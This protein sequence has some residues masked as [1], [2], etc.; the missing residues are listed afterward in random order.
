MSKSEQIKCPK[1]NKYVW[2]NYQDSNGNIIKSV[3]EFERFGIFILDVLGLLLFILFN[4][5]VSI[6]IAVGVLI[7]YFIFIKTGKKMKTEQVETQT[8]YPICPKCKEDL[9]NP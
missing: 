9:F 8:F 2:P 7:L 3:G 5:V 4:Y 6:Y 1:C